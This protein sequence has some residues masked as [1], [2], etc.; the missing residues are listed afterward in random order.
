MGIEEE[1]EEVVVLLEVDFVLFLYLFA[2]L[3]DV[4]L[5]IGSEGSDDED[6]FLSR[7]F[8]GGFVSSSYCISNNSRAR[9]D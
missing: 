7:F 5:G 8:F 3:L 6:V 4:L 2:T 9:R 1:E